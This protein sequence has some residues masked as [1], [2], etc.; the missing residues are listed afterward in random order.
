MNQPWFD[1][2]TFGWIPGT[3]YGTS[4]GLLG[5]LAGTLAG[6]GKAR[7]LVTGLLAIFWLLAIVMLVLGLVAW[8][9]GQPYGVWYALM[10]PGFLGNV[11]MPVMWMV[12]RASYR[13]AEHR[14][15]EAS[16]LG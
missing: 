5:G 8:I 12:T 13:Q 16:D 14:R 4:L 6:R 1:P 10:L 11:L 9:T 7:V 15:I 2:A 3:V